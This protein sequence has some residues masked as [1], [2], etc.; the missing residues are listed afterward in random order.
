[1]VNKEEIRQLLFAELAGNKDRAKLQEME[2]Y[3]QPLFASLPKNA[4]GRLDGPFVRY[5][6]NRYFVQK[7]GWHVKGLDATWF[8][9]KS[10]PSTVLKAR[11]PAYIQSLFEE[12][13][14]GR[15][16]GLH[17]L[18]VFVATMAD[19]I[20]AEASG[21]LELIHRVKGLPTGSL[22]PMPSEEADSAIESFLVSYLLIREDGE[23]PEE[24]EESK[25]EL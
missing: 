5:A 4:L 12:R 1:V 14:N 19:L 23:E 16:F 15:G 9:E 3:M 6:L 18:A 13:L 21:M 24:E 7:N 17:E 8:H 2:A 20:H 25:D 22:V 11:A 10:S